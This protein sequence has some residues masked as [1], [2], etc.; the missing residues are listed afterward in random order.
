MPGACRGV[1]W[2]TAGRVGGLRGQNHTCDH[3]ISGNMTSIL[4]SLSLHFGWEPV[5]GKCLS[6][7][8][9]AEQSSLQNQKQREV[10]GHS[11]HLKVDMLVL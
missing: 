8:R 4:M 2:V 5:D 11:R 9:D 7:H 1:M 6:R 10:R 3:D